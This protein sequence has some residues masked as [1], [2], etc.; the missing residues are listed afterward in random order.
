MQVKSGNKGGSAVVR[1]WFALAESLMMT[2]ADNGGMMSRDLQ[3]GGG[4]AFTV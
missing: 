1:C 2:T 4:S 3:I